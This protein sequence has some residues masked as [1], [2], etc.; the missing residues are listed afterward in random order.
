MKLSNKRPGSAIPLQFDI[1]EKHLK[2]CDSKCHK[3]RT[4]VRALQK[5]CQWKGSKNGSTYMIL[6]NL[7]IQ[8]VPKNRKFIEIECE[9]CSGTL[10]S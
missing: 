3:C 7:Y 2:N 5:S 4:H 1:T 10:S 8:F 6:K 9:K